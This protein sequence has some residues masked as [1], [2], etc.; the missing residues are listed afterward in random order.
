[1]IGYV[2]DADGELVGGQLSWWQWCGWRG[3]PLWCVLLTQASAAKGS[4]GGVWAGG[5]ESQY[6]L[7]GGLDLVFGEDWVSA[8]LL[9]R[10]YVQIPVLA[11]SASVP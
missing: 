10:V 7:Y 5:V 1:M 9:S 2:V 8:L 6:P 4:T 11:S 3:G